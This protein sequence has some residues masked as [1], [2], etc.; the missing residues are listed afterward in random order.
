MLMVRSSSDTNAMALGT[1]PPWIF[2][3]CLCLLIIWPCWCL[4]QRDLVNC[5]THLLAHYCLA[6]LN[7]RLL[8]V[9]QL[10]C[11]LYYLPILQPWFIVQQFC[12]D[13]SESHI[14]QLSHRPMHLSYNQTFDMI[15]L[16]I[17][18]FFTCR[19]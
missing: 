12:E 10:S 3:P 11:C 2:W 18:M 17:K 14:I 1:L 9:N 5:P 16:T 6:G 15:K 8:V 19:K 7:L 13:I 4:L